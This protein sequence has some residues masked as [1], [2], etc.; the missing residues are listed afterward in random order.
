MSAI[1]IPFPNR[2][3]PEGWPDGELGLELDGL[4]D[5]LLAFGNRSPGPRVTLAKAREAALIA[6]R[7]HVAIQKRRTCP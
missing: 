3:R 6:Y 5:M 4:A 1:I 7:E 2:S